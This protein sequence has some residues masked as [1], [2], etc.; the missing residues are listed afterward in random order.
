METESLKKDIFFFYRGSYYWL[1]RDD[2]WETLFIADEN[3]KWFF[4]NG[5]ISDIWDT[6]FVHRGITAIEF[7]DLPEDIQLSIIISALDAV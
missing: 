2:D 1:V 7:H 4:L 5:R 6:E 3:A